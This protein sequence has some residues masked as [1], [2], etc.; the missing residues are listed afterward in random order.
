[1]SQADLL[2]R[3][4]ERRS[5]AR[6][7]A[8][9]LIQDGMA[10]IVRQGPLALPNLES[11]AVIADLNRRI[12]RLQ[13]YYYTE[14]DQKYAKE[15]HVWDKNRLQYGSGNASSRFTRPRGE[16]FMQVPQAQRTRD[17]G[18]VFDDDAEQEDAERRL[19]SLHDFMGVSRDD[20][21]DS[22][23]ATQTD[24]TRRARGKYVW[25]RLLKFEERLQFAEDMRDTAQSEKTKEKLRNF[26]E[27]G[28][29]KT[30]TARILFDAFDVKPGETPCNRL[31]S[32]RLPEYILT[33]FTLSLPIWR[34][35][36]GNSCQDVRAPGRVPDV[37]YALLKPVIFPGS[38]LKR[39]A[40]KEFGSS[41]G[42]M[43]S[44]LEFAR[45]LA[46][47]KHD[48]RLL[49]SGRKR[50]SQSSK[51]YER[52]SI[53]EAKRSCRSFANTGVV[54]SR[55]RVRSGVTRVSD[56]DLLSALDKIKA[57]Y[58]R[59][60]ARIFMYIK[61][62]AHNPLGSM[63]THRSKEGPRPYP[64]KQA[65]IR[66][67]ENGDEIISGTFTNINYYDVVQSTART[68]SLIFEALNIVNGQSRLDFDEYDDIQLNT[69]IR[70]VNGVQSPESQQKHGEAIDKLKPVGHDDF[71]A[72]ELLSSI[73]RESDRGIAGF[74][75]GDV[76]ALIDEASQKID[77][78]VADIEMM[79][80]VLKVTEYDVCAMLA[81]T[82]VLVKGSFL[83]HTY[84]AKQKDKDMVK[85]SRCRDMVG[86]TTTMTEAEMCD[87]GR[88]TGSTQSASCGGVMYLQK[89]PRAYLD[90]LQEYP[91]ALR[92]NRHGS[93]D[94]YAPTAFSKPTSSPPPDVIRSTYLLFV[95]RGPY[96]CGISEDFEDEYRTVFLASDIARA[97]CIDAITS[98]RDSL[99]FF[100][101]YWHSMVEAADDVTLM[102][103]IH[104]DVSA[105]R[106]EYENFRALERRVAA[107]G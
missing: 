92:H 5:D 57:K 74:K 75:I 54:V 42:P 43:E 94:S 80:N 105:L 78:I 66:F 4:R 27:D 96:T 60:D 103:L 76:S 53:T 13:L 106:D 38:K 45:Q 85:R 51:E 17:L 15:H 31:M 37:P 62:W 93:D 55:T 91:V 11:D 14:E 107:R 44:S 10:D 21:L 83:N 97:S 67:E 30:S 25:S 56:S 29:T 35:V 82:P 81:Y 7:G 23:R 69:L 26:L 77:G 89:L 16:K 40:K 100:Q 24:P 1:M 84:H 86:N 87:S 49:L 3:L 71:F 88:S 61:T 65:L 6:E 28:S 47:A 58:D 104:K 70:V 99:R 95:H 101:H 8:Q 68:I 18:A 12:G 19:Q 50:F 48:L 79:A 63:Y 59:K 90:K 32:G 20:I 98:F 2:R 46:M 9:A 33:H 64:F 39:G 73:V 34:Q 41:T 102:K 52:P 22:L 36:F 72:L